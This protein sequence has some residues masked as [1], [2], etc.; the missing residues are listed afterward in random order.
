M[1]MNVGTRTEHTTV[2][3]ARDLSWLR[4]PEHV[5]VTYEQ[6]MGQSSE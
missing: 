3:V 4:I 1:T 2:C 5:M 6:E